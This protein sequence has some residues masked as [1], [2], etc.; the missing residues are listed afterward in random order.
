MIEFQTFL[1][2]VILVELFVQLIAPEEQISGADL[3][4]FDQLRSI[5]EIPESATVGTYVYTVNVK[6]LPANLVKNHR[7]VYS[8][9]K[10]HRVF[11][12]NPTTGY[13]N[14]RLLNFYENFTTTKKNILIYDYQRIKF[15]RLY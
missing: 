9:S 3:V 4:K 6:P 13:F 2:H 11:A 10:G 15:Q 12:I 7:V 14:L 8:L 1:S 5:I